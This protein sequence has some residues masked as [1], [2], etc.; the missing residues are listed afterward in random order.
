MW[1]ESMN[2]FHPIGEHEGVKCK[3]C[4]H[5]NLMPFDIVVTC[6]HCKKVLPRNELVED[7]YTMF[8]FC[9]DCTKIVKDER[10]ARDEWWNKFINGGKK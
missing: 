6:G 1:D 3:K 9:R 8:L 10:R 2:R 4:G 7:D 5:I